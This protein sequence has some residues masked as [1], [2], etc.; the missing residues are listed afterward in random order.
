LVYIA[1]DFTRY[2]EHAVVQINRSIECRSSPAIQEA[3]RVR[4]SRT[5]G[6]RVYVIHTGHFGTG[7]VEIA[8]DSPDDLERAKPPVLESCEAN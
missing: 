4:Q 2:D 8:I 5:A 3:P 1:G 7:N 6:R